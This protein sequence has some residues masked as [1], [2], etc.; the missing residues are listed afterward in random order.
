M[1][2]DGT[3]VTLGLAAAGVVGSWFVMGYRVRVLEKR[4]V[5]FD[6][7]EKKVAEIDT[8]TLASAA[9]QGKRLETAQREVDG[10]RGSFESF[11]RYAMGR[12]SKTA[13]HGHTA[14]GKD[15]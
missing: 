10:L 4:G 11:E 2:S 12:R 1:L 8:R 6:A 9:S 13:A 15:E 3:I 7:L 5:S 14:G